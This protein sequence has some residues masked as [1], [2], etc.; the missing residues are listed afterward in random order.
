MARR[1]ETEDLNSPEEVTSVSI[2]IN[3]KKSCRDKGLTYKRC[4]LV[5]YHKLVNGEVDQIK[6]NNKKIAEIEQ[7]NM[8]LQRKITELSLELADLREKKKV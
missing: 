7:G 6:E 8:K 2:P 3:I 5:G 4:F 1:F